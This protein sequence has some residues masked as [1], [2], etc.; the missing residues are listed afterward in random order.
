MR[1]VSS[2]PSIP[3]AWVTARVV[4]KSTEEG[5][6]STPVEAGTYRPGFHFVGETE[7]YGLNVEGLNP[8][9]LPP[10][11]EGTM[12][13]QFIASWAKVRHRIL[14]GT[15]F[16]LSEGPKVVGLGEVRSVSDEAPS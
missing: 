15:P 13:F 11:A 16:L 3:S 7:G 12:V 10:G 9:P 1:K 14:P 8:N 2:Q 6:R 4:F 5:G